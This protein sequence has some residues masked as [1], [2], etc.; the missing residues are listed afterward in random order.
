MNPYIDQTFFSFIFLFLK[1]MSFLLTGQ[2]GFNELASDELQ[3]LT[4]MT[5]GISAAIVGSFLFLKK[6]TM[7][8]NSLSHTSLLGIAVSYLFMSA[9]TK[10]SLLTFNTSFFLLASV[11]TALITIVF[12]D[13]LKKR[14]H[15]NEEASVGFVFTF[16]FALGV[17]F[18]TLFTKNAHIGIEAIMGNIDAVHLNDLKISSF[19]A[20]VNVTIFS[21]GFSYFKIYCFDETLSHLQRCYPRVIYYLLMMLTASTAIASFRAVGV[22]LFLVFLTA[23]VLTA[24]LVTH[25]LKKLI[26]ISALINIL[27]ALFGV[28][29]SRSLLTYHELSLS[30]GALTA[31]KVALS[32]PLCALFLFFKNKVSRFT[33]EKNARLR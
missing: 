2:M 14:C 1:R 13:F 33:L 16:L 5:I 18:V 23:P 26:F 27:C 3:I 11:V 4:L 6:M 7:L 31:V 25:Q 9:M 24:R 12:I 15:L 19:V 32:Y 28:A 21:I 10:E 20:F 30:T 29:F 22:F 8:A 17:L